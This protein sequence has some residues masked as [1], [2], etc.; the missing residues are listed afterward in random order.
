[1]EGRKWL[2][3]SWLECRSCCKFAELKGHMHCYRVER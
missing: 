3:S 2:L 1:L